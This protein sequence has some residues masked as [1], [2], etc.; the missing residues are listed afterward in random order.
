MVDKLNRVYFG[1]CF[2]LLNKIDNESVD[3]IIIDPPYLLRKKFWDKK[4][5]VND[6][7]SKELFRILKNTGNLYIWC[8]IGEKSQ[9]L[10]KWFPIFNKDFHF[11]DL[12]TWKKRQGMG[13][14]K[15]WLYTR[16]EIIWSVKDNKKF[17]WN[18]DKQY[19]KNEKC[20]FTESFTLGYE[21]LSEFKRHTNVWTDIPQ[22]I[23]KKQMSHFTPKPLKALKRIIE[24]HTKE[25]DIVFDCFA[26][27]GSTGVAAKEMNR[28]FILIEKEKQY[29][30]LSCQRLGLTVVYRI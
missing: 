14:R 1:D 28:N 15:G 9:C 11:K 6:I 27:S 29:C 26:G 4:E 8:G 16:E 19:N 20:V 7:L 22:H 30:N 13:N 2:D 18:K 24:L 17:I 12:M 10:I 25:G 21:C 3:L 23:G 5:V